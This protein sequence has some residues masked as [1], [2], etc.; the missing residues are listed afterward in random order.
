M[1]MQYFN[2]PGE[3]IPKG[4]RVREKPTHGDWTELSLKQIKAISTFLTKTPKKNKS[5]DEIPT[6]CVGE[7]NLLKYS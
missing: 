5:L 2:S 3:M 4:E 6:I 7:F 1:R